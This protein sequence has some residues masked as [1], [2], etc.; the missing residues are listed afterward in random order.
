[1]IDEKRLLEVYR[2]YKKELYIYIFKFTRSQ[3]AAED[4]LQDCFEN[5]IKYSLKYPVEDSNLRSFLYKTAHNLS[6]NHIKKSRRYIHE[7]I[8]EDSCITGEDYVTG[9]VELDELNHTIYRALDQLDE[10]SRSIFIMKKELTLPIS[11]ISSNLGISERTV[12][13]KISK[14]LEYL[15]ESL[16]KS[17]HLQFFLIFLAVLQPWIVLF[18]R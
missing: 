3:E 8:E 10:L 12:R 15:A 6:L 2:L 7:T 14:T 11:E 4:I 18:N 13:R 16:K 17:G 9:E 1:M 5:L